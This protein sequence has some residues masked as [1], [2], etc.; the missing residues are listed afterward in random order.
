MSLISNVYINVFPFS[1]ISFLK[2]IL[3]NG[4]IWCKYI[5]LAICL[6]AWYENTMF[7][8]TLSSL[9]ILYWCCNNI[10]IQCDGQKNC[11]Y[12]YLHFNNY[13]CLV[14]QIYFITTF[15]GSKTDLL[16]NLML[17]RLYRNFTIAFLAR[18]SLSY[19]FFTF[20]KNYPH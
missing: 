15:P 1:I 13:W 6:L 9:G 12:F 16:R 2:W 4:I 17:L 18:K 14:P 8:P 7:T 5:F 10:F 11:N 3:G 19:L 20:L